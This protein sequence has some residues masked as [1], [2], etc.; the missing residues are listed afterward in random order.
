MVLVFSGNA[1]N[2]DEIKKE[3]VLAGQSRLVVIPVRV[4]DVAPG[5]AFAYEFATRQW[6]DLFEDWEGSIQRL[7]RQLST[8]GIAATG[9]Q[10]EQIK[11]PTRAKSRRGAAILAAIIV[12][13]T[14]AAA[15]W[16]W[17]SGLTRKEFPLA[18]IQAPLRP[19]A[20]IPAPVPAAASAGAST[21]ACPVEAS[22]FG[23]RINGATPNAVTG[24]LT[25]QASAGDE[26]M[27]IIGRAWFPNGVKAVS[28]G[29]SEADLFKCGGF[30]WGLLLRDQV[31]PV[32]VVATGND[33]E[34]VEIQ[35]D[36]LR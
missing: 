12:L 8:V 35:V 19:V 21:P 32:H 2:S 9:G 23:I 31:T 11:R 24:H 4:E 15:G 6:I 7:V 13:V 3:V 14:V 10:P 26:I 25:L 27:S 16:W 34:K 17:S 28:I 5:E 30:S 22:A 20:P 29:D 1:N 33:F 18:A 36:I